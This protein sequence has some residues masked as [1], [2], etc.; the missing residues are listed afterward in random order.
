MAST[1]YR[2]ERN[3]GKGLTGL[4]NEQG[5]VDPDRLGW[6]TN[7]HRGKRP[8]GAVIVDITGWTTIDATNATAQVL[9]FI[10]G[11]QYRGLEREVEIFQNTQV[12]LTNCFAAT[13]GMIES[14]EEIMYTLQTM[15]TSPGTFKWFDLMLM[16]PAHILM[17]FTV[18]WQMCDLDLIL[19]QFKLMAGFD[20]GAI[21][22]QVTREA[23]AIWLESSEYQTAI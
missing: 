10:N 2:L 21:M 19:H 5:Q 6:M 22:D 23:L 17:D 3:F 13:Y 4:Y 12:E 8:L 7:K 15:N 16:D 20:Y 18:Q 9:G 1:K 14:I 11:L